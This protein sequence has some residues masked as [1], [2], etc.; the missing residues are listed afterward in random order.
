MIAPYYVDES[1]TLYHGRCEDVLPTIAPA[2]VN[3]LLT[4]PPYFEVKDDEWDNQ[5]AH[6]SEFLTW[7]GSVLDLAKPTLTPNASTWVFAGPALASQVE[8][9]VRERFRVLNHVRWVKEQGW[10]QKADIAAQRRYLTP[11]EG[12]VFAEQFGDAVA[13][14]SYGEYRDAAKAA[15]AEAFAPMGDYFRSERERHGISRS[16]LEV[17]LGYVSSSDPTKGTALFTRWEEGAALPTRAA[18]V[19]LRDALGHGYFERE[20]EDLKAEGDR[21]RD[22]YLSSRDSYAH[23]RNEYENL[24]RPFSLKRTGPVSDVWNFDTVAPYAGKHPCEK[25]QALLRHMIDVSS[26]P[27]DLILDPFAGSGSTLIAARD[28]GRRATGIEMDLGY[29]RRIAERLSQGAFNFDEASA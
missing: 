15:H 27:G 2:S 20:Y 9:V 17:L 14:E 22:V 21:L 8:G 1:V 3:L 16:D 4:D 23:L 11:W 13:E 10:H 7:L 18:Y 26:R 29:C 19:R 24:R 6:A 25:P 28:A 5:W 12:I